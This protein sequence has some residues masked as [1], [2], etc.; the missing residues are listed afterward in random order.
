VDRE[1]HVAP[2][3][4]NGAPPI[5]LQLEAWPSPGKRHWRAFWRRNGVVDVCPFRIWTSV[6]GLAWPQVVHVLQGDVWLRSAPNK[7]SYQ[8]RMGSRPEA[9]RPFAVEPGCHS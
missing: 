4:G 6:S 5:A 3:V 8:V 9:T 7:R 2:R 1:E